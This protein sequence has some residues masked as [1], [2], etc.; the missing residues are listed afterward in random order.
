[1]CD[2][3]QSNEKEVWCR[4]TTPDGVEPFKSYASIKVDDDG[5]AMTLCLGGMCCKMS[6][7]QWHE[8]ASERCCDSC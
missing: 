2:A 7:E 6:I 3:N 8:M 5:S 4:E 1:M